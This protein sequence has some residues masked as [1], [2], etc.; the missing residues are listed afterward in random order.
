LALVRP[1]Q[2]VSPYIPDQRAPSIR[3]TTTTVRHGQAKFRQGLL[4]RD[5]VCIITGCPLRPMIDAAHIRPMKL[6]RDGEY[7]DLDNGML[8]RADL[9]KAFDNALFTIGDDG[10]L[11]VDPSA[12]FT[13]AFNQV[14]RKL[15][16]GQR[17][18][19]AG[20]RQWFLARQSIRNR[21]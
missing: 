9:H 3:V 19:L 20:H 18:Y 17:A 2:D 1:K 11:I 8:L 16:S 5:K 21:K 7:Y 15:T 10:V 6:C 12:W 14:R 4:R 13:I